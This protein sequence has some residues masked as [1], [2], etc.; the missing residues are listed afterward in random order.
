MTE[1]YFLF[2]FEPI[3]SHIKTQKMSA[4]LKEEIEAQRKSGEHWYC[5]GSYRK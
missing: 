3:S 1:D 4:E 5:P 2:N